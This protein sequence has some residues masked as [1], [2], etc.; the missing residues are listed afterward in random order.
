MACGE[1]LREEKVTKRADI[2]DETVFIAA[3]IKKDNGYSYKVRLTSD[4]KPFWT[5]SLSSSL[6][7]EHVIRNS[8]NLR[9]LR[10]HPA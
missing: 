7:S 6:M 1:I 8:V 5:M 9:L 2:G 10:P 4:G 3:K